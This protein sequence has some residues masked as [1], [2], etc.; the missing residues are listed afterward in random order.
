MRERVTI[1]TMKK[2]IVGIVVIILIAGA[3]GGYWY[4]FL[5][6]EVAQKNTTKPPTAEEKASQIVAEASQTE[7]DVS[8]Q[9]KKLKKLAGE[10]SSKEDK[11]TY[12]GSAV[13]V[14]TNAG[15]DSAAF[16]AAKEYEDASQ[17]A[18]SAA[19]LAR[20]YY[21]KGDYKNA[22][23][24]YGIAADRSEKPASANERAPY[25]DYMILKHEA[26]SHF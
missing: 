22:A 13:D 18:L 10:T 25:N 8:E 5:R 2:L 11:E 9:A 4:F 20:S 19:A 1:S 17:S 12:L 23:K 6:E 24:Y 16:G 14:Y 21:E 7:G 26:E 3:V 15:D